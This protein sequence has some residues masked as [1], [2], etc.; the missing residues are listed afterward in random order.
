MQLNIGKKITLGFLLGVLAVL[1]VGGLSYWGS[2]RML[3]LAK[4]IMQSKEIDRILAQSELDHLMWAQKVSTGVIN[5]ETKKLTVQVDPRQCN[6]GKWYYG[7]GR[8]NAE[9]TAPYLNT[10]LAGMDDP[11]ARLHHSAE[12]INEFLDRGDKEGAR[13]HYLQ[14]ARPIMEGLVATFGQMR[15]EV[16]KNVMDDQGLVSATRSNQLNVG[17][18]CMVFAGALAITAFLIRKNILALLRRMIASLQESA[19]QTAMS[20][21]QISAASQSLAEGASEQA[22][23]LEE[24][25]SSMEEMASMTRQNAENARQANAIMGDTGKVVQEAD[26][27]MEELTRSMTEITVSSEQIAKIIR[28]I[29]EIAFQTNLLALNAAVEAARAGEAGAGFAVVADEVR[30]LAMRAADSAK[31]TADLIEGAVKNI[32][33][34]SEIV[35]RTNEAFSKV[36]GGAVRAE[37]L[38]G[39]IAAASQE[40][41]QGIEQ[42]SRAVSEM[43]RIVQQNASAA[44]ESAS[45][46]NQLEGQAENLQA[47]VEELLRLAVS[48]QGE[49]TPAV[50][51]GQAAVFT[52]GSPVPLQQ[53]KRLGLVSPPGKILPKPDAGSGRVVSPEQ[54][55][56]QADDLKEM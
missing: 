22:A 16:K 39:E 3:G 4:S 7:E 23:G 32:C 31:N 40:Q 37:S 36:A 51:Q 45:A 46:S 38:I 44:E 43:D 48:N 15:E 35:A 20:S 1:V 26:Q 42:I 18:L 19:A 33:N 27:A 13:H 8:K 41:A 30:N 14:E 49:D 24:T 2:G 28:T 50:S 6:F 52:G 55:I 21:K 25:S 56:P 5:P 54:I 12:K 34:G 47:L 9:Q 11:H 17:L 10:A 29:D 53:R